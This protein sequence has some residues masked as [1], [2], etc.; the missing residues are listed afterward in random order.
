MFKD[1]KRIAKHSIVYGAGSVS[2]RAIGFFLI[3][4]YT[5]LLTPSDY[6]LMS[7]VEVTS[8]MLGIFLN[9]GIAPAMFRSYFAHDS[10]NDRNIVINTAFLFLVASSLLLVL[11]LIGFA[12]GLSAILFQNHK[13]ASFVVLIAATAFFTNAVTVPFNILRVMEKSK[14]Y[15]ALRFLGA[16]TKLVLI[17]F[18]VV[19]LRKGVLGFLEAGIIAAVFISLMFTPTM[20]R[21][22]RAGFSMKVLKGLLSFGLPLVPGAIA[23]WVFTVS[24]RL[25]LQHFSTLGEVGLYSLG[26][27]FAMIISLLLVEPLRIALPSVMFS[28]AKKEN[29]KKFYSRV[30]TYFILISLFVT[31]GVSMFIKDIIQLVATAEYLAAYKVVPIIALV[32]LIYGI[33]VI[34]TVGIN[35]KNKMLNLPLATGI[36]AVSNL[37]LNFMLI[38]TY[39]AMGAAFATLIS[40]FLMMLIMLWRSQKYYPVH[41]EFRRICVLMLVSCLIY[42]FSLVAPSRGLALAITVKSFLLF[43]F[44]LVLYFFRFYYPEEKKRILEHVLSLKKNS[45]FNFARA[46]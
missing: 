13:Y 20:L 19:V 17:I 16:L 14:K 3:P 4:V 21:R 12:P 8:L 2:T 39:G 6:G 29:A 36:G 18:F 44:P 43:S 30:L 25:F 15:A 32:Y 27:K 1:L 22:I 23:T 11:P 31:L 24:D 46:K 35:L 28:V 40:Y 34:L 26:Y 5:R 33:F 7:I 9:M 41:Y 37:L 38:P 10:E 42:V 45:L